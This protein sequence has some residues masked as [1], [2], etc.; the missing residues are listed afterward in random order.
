MVNV[1]SEDRNI[2]KIE[3]IERKAEKYIE[4]FSG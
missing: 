4:V 1:E 2:T 3:D